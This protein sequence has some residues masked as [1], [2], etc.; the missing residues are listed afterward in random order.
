[1][2]KSS[3]ETVVVSSMIMFLKMFE[4]FFIVVCKATKVFGIWMRVELQELAAI[5]NYY[6]LCA[7]AMMMPSACQQ[8]CILKNLT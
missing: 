1:M 3:N 2:W 4:E 8:E 5:K 6:S 7:P